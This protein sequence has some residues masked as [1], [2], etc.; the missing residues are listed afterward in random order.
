MSERLKI[1]RVDIY[2]MTASF[3]YPFLIA[4]D[5]RSLKIPPISTIIGILEA[6]I[7]DY[8]PVTEIGILGY[9]FNYEGEFEDL[10]TQWTVSNTY[11]GGTNISRRENLVDAKLSIYCDVKF[12]KYFENPFYQ[13]LLG[14]S[15]D[16]AK[17][18][19]VNEITLEKKTSG[20]IGHTILPFIPV[21][22]QFA[23]IQTLPTSFTNT[24][25]RKPIN[26]KK[27][28]IVPEWAEIES[29]VWYDSEKDWDVFLYKNLLD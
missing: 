14:R 15:C 19:M 21:K 24:I 26:P 2:S 5:Q 12:R 10:E 11:S 20:K 17:I 9:I 28:V 3:R 1:L 8:L 7:G 4:G 13:V 23:I 25:P 22:S 27:Y 29:E 6:V 18:E 16:L